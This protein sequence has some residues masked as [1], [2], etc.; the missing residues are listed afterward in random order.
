[1][2]EIEKFAFRSISPAI[3]GHLSPIRISSRLTNYEKTKKKIDSINKSLF[4]SEIDT[5]PILRLEKAA[6]RGAGVEKLMKNKLKIRVSP[7]KSHLEEILHKEHKVKGEG[8]QIVKLPKLPYGHHQTYNE[9]SCDFYGS[10][11]ISADSKPEIVDELRNL[12]RKFKL[13]ERIKSKKYH[14]KSN[15]VN[16]SKNEL[17]VYKMESGELYASTNKD[18]LESYEGDKSKYVVKHHYVYQT[19]RKLG[20]NAANDMSV[21]V[22]DETFNEKDP[23]DEKMKIKKRLIDVDG[24]IKRLYIAPEKKKT[25]LSRNLTKRYSRLFDHS[26]NICS[27]S[28]Q[29]SDSTY[30]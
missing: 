21:G 5:Q 6:M 22:Y 17:N 4:N 20:T 2:E 11:F 16:A 24:L 10:H 25:E 1:M 8:T 9:E 12:T 14:R 18:I 13:N 15:S 23:V 28:N 30:K 7:V 3:R 19:F 29:L 27:T 26:A